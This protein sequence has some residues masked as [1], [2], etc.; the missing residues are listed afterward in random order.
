MGWAPTPECGSQDLLSLRVLGPGQR[1]SG[2][3]Q[4]PPT[5]EAGGPVGHTQRQEPPR[6]QRW[7]GRA[8][9]IAREQGANV[10]PHCSSSASAQGMPSHRQCRCCPHCITPMQPIG[11]CGEHCRGGVPCSSCPMSP[12]TGKGARERD[13]PHAGRAARQP[14][15][16]C[17]RLARHA[18]ARRVTQVPPAPR[19]DQLLL[20][21]RQR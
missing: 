8:S 5:A 19:Q 7:P 10:G 9:G 13:P 1:D 3:E 6:A 4:I 16:L 17:T 20:P 14:G 11:A 18:A 2:T 15:T 12:G 21:P